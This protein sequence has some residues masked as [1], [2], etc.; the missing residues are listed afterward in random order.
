METPAHLGGHNFTTHVD[1]GALRCLI[2]LY[3]IRSMVDVGCATGGQVALAR[4]LGLKAMGIDGDPSL[5][6]DLRHD[7]RMPLV[8]IHFQADLVWCVEFLEHLEEHFLSNVAPIFGHAKYVLITAAPPG[9]EG[10]HH[11]NC[12][13]AQYWVE[14]F[15]T[16]GFRPNWRVLVALMRA[17]TMRKDFIRRWGLFFERCD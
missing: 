1:E 11:V 6:P 10:H 7:F 2:N 5:N 9:T 14:W 17:S 4:A 12:Q 15:D 8:P 16:L 13:P 3:G